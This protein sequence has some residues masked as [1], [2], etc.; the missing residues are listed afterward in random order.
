MKKSNILLVIVMVALQGFFACKSDDISPQKPNQS[1][2][3]QAQTLVIENN[4]KKIEKPDAT[5]KIMYLK[6]IEHA[7]LFLSGLK[8]KLDLTTNTTQA[9]TQWSNP[10]ALNGLVSYGVFKFQNGHIVNMSFDV[11]GDF[12]SLSINGDNDIFRHYE[13]QNAYLEIIKW[14]VIAI[15][16][17]ENFGNSYQYY[18]AP[19]IRWEMSLSNKWSRIQSFN[20]E[21]KLEIEDFGTFETYFTPADIIYEPAPIVH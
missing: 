12:S 15:P 17:I 18:Y 14:G 11:N 1:L 16:Q 3:P 20:P 7:K 9:N 4:L 19:I 8:G 13:P 6:D 5:V 2:S 10:H 21:A